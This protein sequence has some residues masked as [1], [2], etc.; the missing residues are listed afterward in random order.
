M[1]IKERH[2]KQ[3]TLDLLGPHIN[4]PI[5]PGEGGG[6]FCVIYGVLPPGT[7]VPLH[8]HKDVEGLYIVS[9]ELD[10]VLEDSARY[11]PI[12]AAAGD[13][14]HIPSLI[15]HGMK[16]GSASDTWVLLVT[17]E[18]IGRFFEN[19]GEPIVNLMQVPAPSSERL[20]RF[21][22]AARQY[23]FWLGSLEDNAAAGPL[24]VESQSV[25][26]RE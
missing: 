7:I 25:E 10:V 3:P 1:I 18:R 22:E 19:I 23:G 17:T 26:C 2:L 4:F 14:V 21:A 20:R 5:A 9:G 6:S 24:M 13:F 12:T 11:R 15:K 16:N 8:S